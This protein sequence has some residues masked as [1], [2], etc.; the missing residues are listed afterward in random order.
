MPFDETV[1]AGEIHSYKP[2]LAPLARV[3]GA[4]ARRPAAARPR[5]REPLPRHRPGGE[6]PPPERLDQPPR[7]SI[8]GPRRRGSCPTSPELP[9]TLDELIRLTSRCNRARARGG[10]KIRSPMTETKIDVKVE[11]META[12][13]REEAPE[14]LPELRLAL[15]RR[16]ARGGALRLR[17]VRP[18]LPDAGAGPDRLARRSP[19]RS[20]SRPT[21]VRSA[22]PLDFFDLRPYVERLAEAELNTGLADAIVVGARRST[23][24][25]SSWR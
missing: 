21:E 24:I 1:V 5:R 9:D 12:A 18:P 19:A 4:H 25:R 17:P 2:A 22:D 3:L 15:P 13:G 14:H 23:A 11:Q 8:P 20:S 10:S 7:T 16:R 6:A